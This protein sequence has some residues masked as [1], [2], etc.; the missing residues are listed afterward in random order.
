MEIFRVLHTA[1]LHLSNKEEKR[2]EVERVLGAIIA[3]AKADPPDVIVL[4]GDTLDE[5]D[6]PIRLDSD[7]ARSAICHIRELAD[8]APL[9]IVR[10]TR[11]HDRESPFIFREIRANHPIHVST[12]IEQIALVRDYSEPFD[13]ES[14]F[15]PLVGGH[16]LHIRAIFTCIPSPDK[17]GLVA[18]F[19]GESRM[20]TSM[21][22]R[23]A[24]G[25]ALVALGEVNAT[26]NGPTVL[27]AHGM[28]TGA[29]Y[30]TGMT[31]TGEDFEFSLED[32]RRANCA[33][34][35]FGH[36]HEHQSFAGNIHY[37]GSPGRLNHGEKGAKGF[38]VHTLGEI[39]ATAFIET[40]AR[41][42]I[43]IEGE[44]ETIMENVRGAY[45]LHSLTDADV[46]VRY[47]VEEERRQEVD[48]NEISSI[49][50]GHGARSVKIEQTII[51]AVRQ[52]AAG[53]SQLSTL[54]EKLLKWGASTDTLITDRA[55]RI[56]GTIES[57]TEG[58]AVAM[59]EA[60]I[61]NIEVNA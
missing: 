11:S 23:E 33:V 51:P 35:C 17:A 27:V 9:L 53:I 22:A 55:T 42:M 28:I 56:A 7:A 49:I 50:L 52:R 24:L 43:T 15:L 5:H 61:N 45:I 31:A 12:Q 4:A 26:F 58:E 6:G 38:L 25:D 37:S 29:T 30:G 46:R 20:E 32:I 18:A 1:D 39:T 14:R 60:A 48:R 54:P 19:G 57:M 8:I 40:P 47:T 21:L 34:S 16:I 3:H 44:T 59:A 10:G 36:V 41:K 2:A 13:G